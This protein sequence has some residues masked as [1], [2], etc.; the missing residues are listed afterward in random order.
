VAKDDNGNLIVLTP[1]EEATFHLHD[2]NSLSVSEASIQDKPEA[3]DAG[4]G[5]GAAAQTDAPG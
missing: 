4:Q 5:Q 1:G 3:A 2:S